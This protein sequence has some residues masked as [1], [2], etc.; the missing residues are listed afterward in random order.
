MA[1]NAYFPLP[2]ENQEG[3]NAV[4]ILHW[5]VWLGIFAASCVRMY[6]NGKNYTDD[7]TRLM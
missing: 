1:M 6:S 7:T 5:I 2:A 4:S 3:G